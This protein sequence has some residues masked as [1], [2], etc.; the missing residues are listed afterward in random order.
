MIRP[1]TP[2]VLPIAALRS[3]G[4]AVGQQARGRRRRHQ[5]G[6]HKDVTHRA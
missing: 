5:H 6:Q 1:I 2:E 4:Q 3:T